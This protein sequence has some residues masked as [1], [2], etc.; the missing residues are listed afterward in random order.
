M[1]S[2]FVQKWIYD[3]EQV[4]MPVTIISEEKILGQ[5]LIWYFGHDH[6]YNDIFKIINNN[7]LF[8]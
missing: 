6:Y 7:Q 2:S 8:F 4:G 3:S 5:S 1:V